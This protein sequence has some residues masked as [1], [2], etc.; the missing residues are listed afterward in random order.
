MKCSWLSLGQGERTNLEGA[1]DLRAEEPLAQISRPTRSTSSLGRVRGQILK[2][3]WTS[4]QKNPWRRSVDLLV[5][6][7]CTSRGD[8]SGA[9]LWFRTR[10]VDRSG[11]THS[12]TVYVIIRATSG[13]CVQETM[14]PL[15]RQASGFS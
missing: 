13:L 4:G 12:H 9:S 11:R 15:P 5:R 6:P 7:C 8:V 14:S 1:V 3:L 10:L 2:V